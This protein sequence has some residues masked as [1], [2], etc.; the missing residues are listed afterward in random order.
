MPPEDLGKEIH[1]RAQGDDIHVFKISPFQSCRFSRGKFWG[2]E[3]PPKLENLG[4]ENSE[5]YEI[6]C[7]FFRVE[8]WGG[9]QSSVSGEACEFFSGSE[10]LSQKVGIS[11][12]EICYLH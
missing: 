11:G 1:G 4:G 12:V 5:P 7:F 3:N 8:I 2:S 10:D 6:G 9:R